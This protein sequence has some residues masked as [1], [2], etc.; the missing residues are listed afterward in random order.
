MSNPAQHPE[1]GALL[2]YLDG[3][4]GGRDAREVQKHIEACWQCRTELEELQATVAECMRYRKNVLEPLLPE[5]PFAWRDLSR[6]FA[7]IDARRAARGFSFAWLKYS[8]AAAAAAAVVCTAVYELQYAPSVRAATLLKQAEATVERQPQ[9]PHRIRVRTKGQVLLRTVDRRHGEP[10]L[11][12]ALAARFE[13]DRYDVSDPLS[14]RSFD[15][16][17]GGLSGKRDEVSTVADPERPTENCYRIET[18]ADRGDI[19]SAAIL[20]RARDF[21]PVESKFQFRDADWVEFSEMADSPVGSDDSPVATRMETPLRPAEPSRPAAEAPRPL[22]SV[23]DELQVLSALH[24]IGADLGDPV[25]VK[26][27]GEHVLVSG[28]GI[29]PARQRQI[30]SAVNGLPHVEVQFGVPEQQAAVAPP[31]QDSPAPPPTRGTTGETKL[32]A[33]LEEQLGGR[34]EME[35]FGSRVLDLNEALMSRAYALRSLAQRFPAGSEASMSAADRET[36]HAMAREHLSALVSQ[37]G[38][39]ERVLGPVLKSVG[40]ATP[41]QHAA[42]SANWQGSAEDVFRA[43][44]RVEVLLSDLLGVA[45]SQKPAAGLPTDL[46][47]AL[48]DLQASVA[49]C[50]TAVSR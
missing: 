23:T 36:L 29:P 45:A 47:S 35:R 34:A 11:P 24:Q 42:A 21:S 25:E 46:Q 9:T 41:A 39:M 31:Q 10:A 19:A 14:P 13:A 32:Q 20:L 2:R 15:R 16:W 40:A 8:V 26:L 30:Q 18:V 50:Q 4:L 17:R 12:V 38:T 33:R 48:A 49:A 6:G 1:G 3:E 27:A 43:S 7:E 44:R 22:A 5:P 28:M 37:S